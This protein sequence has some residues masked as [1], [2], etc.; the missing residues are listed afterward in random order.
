MA[1]GTAF[2]MAEFS[3]TA[4]SPQHTITG[5]P[6]SSVHAQQQVAD[7]PV[8]GSWVVMGGSRAVLQ[9]DS[10]QPSARDNWCAR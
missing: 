10:L 9:Q 3:K 4:F 2:S 8:G 7:L 5:V 6:G 1:T